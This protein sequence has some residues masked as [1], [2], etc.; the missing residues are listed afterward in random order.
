MMSFKYR[1]LLYNDNNIPYSIYR[2]NT[3]SDAPH[4]D[5]RCLLCFGD[6][7]LYV[8]P[9]AHLCTDE[10]GIPGEADGVSNQ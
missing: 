4:P 10:N 2:G 3:S 7:V 9:V 1:N 8:H 5:I 6:V